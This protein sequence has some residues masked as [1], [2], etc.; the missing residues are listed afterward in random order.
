MGMMDRSGHSLAKELWS[1]AENAR[2]SERVAAALRAYVT[3]TGHLLGDSPTSDELLEAAT[4]IVREEGAVEGLS[5]SLLSRNITSARRLIHPTVS[6]KAG[7]LQQAP[8]PVCEYDEDSAARRVSF[9]IRIRPFSAQTEKGRLATIKEAIRLTLNNRLATSGDWTNVRVCLWTV[10]VMRRSDRDKDVDNLVKGL[11]DTLQGVLYK[12][13]AAIQHLST[14]K[15]RHD[16][17]DSFY[18]VDVRPVC[19]YLEDVIAPRTHATWPGMPE[20][21]V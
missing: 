10:A 19:S 4:W 11:L 9:P 8:C 1:L 6:W 13:D 5:M 16:G 14:A 20:I 7:W 3:A 2:P 15:L 12:N 21:V 18:L 17:D